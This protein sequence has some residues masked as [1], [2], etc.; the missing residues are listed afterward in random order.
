MNLE[1][2]A[3]EFN[4]STIVHFENGPPVD[5][6]IT[7]YIQNILP[8][9]LAFGHFSREST[10]ERSF[11]VDMLPSDFEVVVDSPAGA[12]FVITEN[13][14]KGQSP[15]NGKTT[16]TIKTG[17]AM[18]FGSIDATATVVSSSGQHEIALT[19]YVMRP[20]E[21]A[22]Q[23]FSFG[24]IENPQRAQSILFKTF[25]ENAVRFLDANS[26][27]GCLSFSESPGHANDSIAVDVSFRSIPN[28]GVF[29]EVVSFRFKSGDEVI[30]V[31][32]NVYGYVPFSTSN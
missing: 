30:E 29:K 18:P 31:P 11:T 25:G 17:A 5:L 14:T 19:G 7:G 20:V 28:P 23:L 22:E 1:G 6:T 26:P 13:E 9:I 24:Q 16:V 27:C 12:E 15:T 4:V 3:G 10:V 32:A 21:P 2:K 8:E